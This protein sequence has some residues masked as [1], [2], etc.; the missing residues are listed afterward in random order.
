VA[1]EFQLTRPLRPRPSSQNFFCGRKVRC[2][3]GAV[4]MKMGSGLERNVI[5]VIKEGPN[6][7]DLHSGNLY[8]ATPSGRA[9][10]GRVF[11][12]IPKTLSA[13]ALKASPTS[14]DSGDQSR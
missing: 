1:G 11:K 7:S 3:N 4:E 9:S 6:P 13:T 2:H 5:V 10:A 8:E 14:A 12:L